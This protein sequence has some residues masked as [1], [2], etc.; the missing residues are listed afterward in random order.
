MEDANPQNHEVRGQ[1]RVLY[2]PKVFGLA[3]ESCTCQ[4]PCA[5][6][7]DAVVIVEWYPR[8]DNVS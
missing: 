3:C 6:A 7:Y 1:G 2:C 8:R 4:V 5:D